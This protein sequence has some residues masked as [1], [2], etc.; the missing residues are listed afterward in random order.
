MIWTTALKPGI[1]SS[2]KHFPHNSG[3]GVLG[4]GFVFRVWG[5]VLLRFGAHCLLF[6]VAFGL[7]GRPRSN[8]GNA[9][10]TPLVFRGLY[11]YKGTPTL[12]KEV[13]A[14]SGSYLV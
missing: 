10:G 14:S 1:A 5:F 8:L 3:F 7:L 11:N 12:K 13:R 4:L 9:R 6:V 2:S